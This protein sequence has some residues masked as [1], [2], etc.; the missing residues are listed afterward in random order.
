MHLR[1]R[2]EGA[3]DDRVEAVSPML[4]EGPPDVTTDSILRDL[5][6]DP[7]VERA[8]DRIFAASSPPRNGNGE[9]VGSDFVGLNLGSPNTPAVLN[10]AEKH[11]RR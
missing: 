7:D 11:A 2:R 4:E 5:G 10:N 6:V 3:V 1:E 9:I 8:M